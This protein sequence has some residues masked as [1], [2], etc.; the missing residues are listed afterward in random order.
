MSRQLKLELVQPAGNTELARL[1]GGQVLLG[2]EPDDGGIVVPNQAISRNHAL[3]AK[4]RNHWFY[5]DLGSTN[6]SWINGIQAREGVWKL[7]RPGD[8]VQMA[9]SAL[10]VSDSGDGST[11]A[12]RITGF[13]AL[14]GVSLLVFSKGEFIDEFP[15][16]D[17]GRALVLGGSQGDLE[18][19]GSLNE[20]PSLIIERLSANVCAQTTSRNIKVLINEK[21]L[22]G[23]VTLSD[24]DEMSVAHYYI[25]FN[26]PPAAG[27]RGVAA[28]LRGEPAVIGERP[29][30]AYGG[31]KEWGDEG[32]RPDLAQSS[33]AY[34]EP[35]GSAPAG[36]G[37]FGTGVDQDFTADETVAI[38]ADEVDKKISGYDMHPSMRYMVEEPEPSALA[39][40]DEKIV[41]ILGILLLVGLVGLMLYWLL[42]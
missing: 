11:A 9:D 32:G 21:E 35:R 3:I 14:G 6:G 30:P 15:V 17:Y 38:D 24:R 42:S 16:P 33:P 40:L 27:A 5:K 18:I 19:E 28:S 37:I 23:T 8:M 12:P 39:T 34:E 25:I 13:P 7:I 10:S 36:R 31:W 26:N 41:F 20:A 4:V 29:E 1:Q 22:N 2:R